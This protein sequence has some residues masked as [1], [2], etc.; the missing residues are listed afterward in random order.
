MYIC[1]GRTILL[2]RA[3]LV[4]IFLHRLAKQAADTLSVSD[5]QY[6]LVINSQGKDISNKS[7]TLFDLQL[8]HEFVY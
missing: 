1:N 4:S 7:L 2:V 8:L 6:A 5:G 3:D